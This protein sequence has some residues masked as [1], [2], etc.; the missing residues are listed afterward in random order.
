M[1]ER[2]ALPRATD[3]AQP[4]RIHE[5]QKAAR[6]LHH[7]ITPEST[8]GPVD[9]HGGKAG[10]IGNMLLTQRKWETLAAMH[11]A[12]FK[13]VHE[14]Q[15]QSRDALFGRAP[16]EINEERIA[17]PPLENGQ[18]CQHIAKIRLRGQLRLEIIA[19]V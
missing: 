7:P 11:A 9:V 10:D 13:P 4:G 14:T 15:D 5:L 12:R 1:Q 2:P 6:N 16:A 3:T 8:Q 18:P 19:F 17:L